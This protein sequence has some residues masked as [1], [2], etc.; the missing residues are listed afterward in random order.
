MLYTNAH[1]F[2][3]SS[4]PI[5]TLKYTP[6]LYQ[7]A[8]TG[9][10]D[11]GAEAAEE[12]QSNNDQESDYTFERFDLSGSSFGRQ[13][14][15]TAVRGEA[16]ALRALYDEN[17]PDRSD[18][19]VI[20]DD[21]TVV[22]DEDPLSGTKVVQSEE[23]G[24][25]FKV[26][27]TDDGQTKVLEGMG[28]DFAGNTFYG[29]IEDDFDADRIALKRG[30]GAGRS[31]ATSLEGTG[32]RTARAQIERDEEG[33][34]TNIE[35][36]DEGWPAHNGGYIEYDNEGDNL[37]RRA[38]EP[39]LREDV[40]GQEVVVMIQRLSEIDPDYDGAAYWATV[41]ASLDDER[42]TELAE[43][44]AEQSDGKSA[45]DFITD[46][47]GTDFLKLAPTEEFEPSEANLE[48][49]GWLEWSGIDTSSAEEVTLLNQ[50]RIDNGFN[51]IWVP[52]GMDVDAVTPDNAGTIEADPDD[53]DREDESVTIAFGQG[54]SV[55]ADE[56]EAE[57]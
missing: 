30:G 11:V 25:Q 20:L 41:F 42:Q 1:K 5:E 28:I 38:R 17:D 43:Q 9:I 19:A 12:S 22:T 51:S 39:E 23:E 2:I 33:T 21:P 24:D 35:L 56:A 6:T 47:G 18:V 44:Y 29:D 3:P 4:T 32:A 34:L 53:E 7:I 26:V 31:I 46:L 40:D 27:N 13:H 8:M 48:D 49:N 36:D 55:E 52:D 10:T 16:V 54:V 15:T 50:T 14:P 57:A 37:P 45:E